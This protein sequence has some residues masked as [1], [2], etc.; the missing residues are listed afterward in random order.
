VHIFTSIEEF[1]RFKAVTYYT[2]RREGTALSETDDFFRRMEIEL[3]HSDQLQRL[4]IWIEEIGGMRNGAERRY[5]RSEGLCLALPPNRK[6]LTE[7]IDLR[8]Y[9]YLVS[10]SIVILY[11]GGIKTARTAQD[12]PNVSRHFHNAQ[13][14]T[15]QLLNIGIQHRYR[16]IINIEQLNIKLKTMPSEIFRRLLSQVTPENRQFVKRN[17]AISYQVHD[18]LDNHPTIKTQKALAKVLGKE[19]SEISRWLSGLHNLTL[20]SIIKMEEALGRDIILTDQQ[21]R[22]R[23]DRSFKGYQLFKVDGYKP[24]PTLINFPGWSGERN[25]S[26]LQTDKKTGPIN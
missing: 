2:L 24:S 8:L 17:L 19:P 1:D 15:K 14:W 11:N 5:F 10:H 18:I 23:Y 25:I 9:C 16:T 13:R 6:Y 21:A 12:C 22:E 20:E 26:Y 7:P 3:N 4:L